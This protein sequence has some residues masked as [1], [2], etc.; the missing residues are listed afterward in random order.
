MHTIA[1]GEKICVQFLLEVRNEKLTNHRQIGGDSR[2]T[3]R[4]N[5]PAEILEMLDKRKNAWHFA[6]E[7][8]VASRVQRGPRLKLARESVEL[9]LNLQARVEFATSP[10][11][12]KF[13][14]FK[15]L[16]P[17]IVGIM[18]R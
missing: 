12:I 3:M 10:K 4:E 16:P 2:Q 7:S 15:T 8:S 17:R 11:S 1:Q 5:R 9:F 13:R 18:R 6:P 14:E